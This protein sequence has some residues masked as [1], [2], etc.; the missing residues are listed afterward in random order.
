MKGKMQKVLKISYIARIQRDINGCTTI[1]R[2]RWK[3]LEIRV[4]RR[5]NTCMILQ[6]NKLR[7]NGE[8][9]QKDQTLVFSHYE[10]ELFTAKGL[11]SSSANGLGSCRAIL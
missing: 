4:A 6:H 5:R 11:I 2:F 7:S 10:T 3:W 1:I 8:R 9:L